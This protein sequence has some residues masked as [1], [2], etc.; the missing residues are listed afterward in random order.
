MSDEEN[1]TMIRKK[2][3]FFS[4]EKKQA[5]V[6]LALTFFNLSVKR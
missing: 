1:K 3:I 6:S 4:K 5:P 2:E